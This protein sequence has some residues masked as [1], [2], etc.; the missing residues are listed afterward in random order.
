MCGETPAFYEMNTS[1]V[2][3]FRGDGSNVFSELHALYMRGEASLQGRIQIPHIMGHRKPG[4]VAGVLAPKP[5]FLAPRV[6]GTLRDTG[7]TGWHSVPVELVD[8]QGASIHGYE[9]LI[10]DGRCGPK[11]YDLARPREVEYPAQFAAEWVGFH[12]N[13][14][15]WDGSDL[16]MTTTYSETVVATE[17]VRTA[18]RKERIK[19]FEFV[20]VEDVVLNDLVVKFHPEKAAEMAAFEAAHGLPRDKR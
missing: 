17:K 2:H 19:S 1:V 8:R 10:V 11:R 12:F 14:D 20:P 4:D 6:L 16:F 15:Q 9:M 13:L 18:F 7:A 3:M 5:W